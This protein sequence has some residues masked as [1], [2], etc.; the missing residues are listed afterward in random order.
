MK[1][2]D[3]D[4]VHSTPGFCECGCGQPTKLADQTDTAIGHV[5]G[6]PI[7]FIDGHQQRKPVIK[8]YRVARGERNKRLHR[9]R[10]ERAL[11]KPLPPGAQVH[12]AD[13]TKGDASPLVICENA[14]YH[15]LLHKLDRIRRAGGNPHG[16]RICWKCHR[17]LPFA[18]FPGDPLNRRPREGDLCRLCGKTKLENFRAKLAARMS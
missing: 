10:A 17:V 16:D 2:T 12:H 7:R 8:T 3:L 13:G 1:P 5:R 15:R 9:L 11:G 6:M 18:A 4:L 14:A